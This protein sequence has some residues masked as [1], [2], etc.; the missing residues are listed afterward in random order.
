MST[1]LVH[2]VTAVCP[3]ANNQIYRQQYYH[4]R[5][6]MMSNGRVSSISRHGES[7]VSCRYINLFILDFIM[8]GEHLNV[9]YALLRR[10]YYN[11]SHSLNGYTLT[12]K[13]TPVPYATFSSVFMM[14][15]SFSN[16]KTKEKCTKLIHCIV[17]CKLF[18]YSYNNSSQLYTSEKRLPLRFL[19]VHELTF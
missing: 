11:Y 2:Y 19:S 8:K 17:H 3:D 6:S 7:S 5:Q 13:P 10:G 16:C 9:Q 4:V 18:F 12:C 15:F 1:K 14:G